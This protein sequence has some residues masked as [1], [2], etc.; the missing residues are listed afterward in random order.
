MAMWS[1]TGESLQR[2]LEGWGHTVSAVQIASSAT[3]TRP[4]QAVTI[5][6]DDAVT[7][8]RAAA[9]IPTELQ[10]ISVD[11]DADLLEHPV[12]AAQLLST[13]APVAMSRWRRGGLPDDPRLRGA[14]LELDQIRAEAHLLSA[15]PEL[16]PAWWCAA[17]WLTRAPFVGSDDAIARQVLTHVCPRADAL[18]VPLTATRHLKPALVGYLGPEVVQQFVDLWRELLAVP[19]QASLVVDVAQ[20]WVDALDTYLPDHGDRAGRSVRMSKAALRTADELHQIAAAAQATVA[21]RREK[22][23]AKPPGLDGRRQDPEVADEFFVEGAGTGLPTNRALLHRPPT[24]ADTEMRKEVTAALS[25]ARERRP[26]LVD[27]PTSSP[28]GRA[29]SRELVA[30]TVQR[31]QGRQITATPWRRRQPEPVLSPRLSV[32]AVFDTSASMA[33]WLDT[34]A[35]L[36]WAVAC[37]AHDLGG[38]ATVWGFGGESFE[39]IRPGSAPAQV[40]HVDNPLAGSTG[41]AAAVRQAAESVGLAGGSG[42]RALVVLT[43]GRLQDKRE[44]HQLQQEIS[45]LAQAGVMVLWLLAAG[46]HDPVVPDGATVSYL[47]APSQFP[48]VVS[49]ALTEALAR[50]R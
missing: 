18:V 4:S 24:G 37:A 29:D 6:D 16:R 46:G 20:R 35:P 33:P 48:S 9:R 21:E 34:A 8:H 25:V 50:A 49:G 3:S 28:V 12:A 1:N 39:V 5:D 40:P 15:H 31:V 38:D 30:W 23:L 14:V 11:T 41:Y 27:A 44:Q 7:V 47:E 42:V 2:A 32:A 22:W 36:M 10:G 26:E 13:I 45:A 19:D 17:P 43:D